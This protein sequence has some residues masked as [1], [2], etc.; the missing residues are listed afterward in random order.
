MKKFL[1]F[2]KWAFL[3]L[4]LM[5]GVGSIHA[6]RIV[7][8]SPK[9]RAS[10]NNLEKLGRVER[11]E[12]KVNK[13]LGRREYE[14]MLLKDPTTGKIPDNIKEK[15]LQYVNSRKAN[16]IDKSRASQYRTSDANPGDL[17]SPWERRGPHNVGGRTRALALDMSDNSGNTILAGG[18]SGGVWRTTNGGTSWTKT[19]GGTEN[20]SITYIAQ[21]PT[22]TDTW[23]Y[24]TGEGSGNSASEDGAFFLGRGVYKSIDN[25]VTWSLLASTTD[26]SPQSFSTPFEVAWKVVVHPSN[27]NVYV[28]TYGA[29]YRSAD[30]GDNWTIVL[31]A[32]DAYYTDIVVTSTGVLYAA[33]SS[34][35]SSDGV[36]RSTDN[37]N[38]WT[39]ITSG[40]P[41]S[42][43]RINMAIAPSNEDI[44]YML[45]DGTS[46]R[47]YKYTYV[48]GDGSGS[49]GTWVN[50]TVNMPAFGG[51]VGDYDSQGGYN[52]I[53][54]VYPSDENIVFVGGTNLYRSTDGFASDE[55]TEWIGGYSTDND[56]S[57][58]ANHHPDQH[59]LI[60]HPTDS[61]IAF[62]S[63]DGGISKTLDI[64][65]IDNDNTP[66]NWTYLNNGY[67]TTQ[68]YTVAIDH[69][70]TTNEYL[71]AG[72]Q[73]N[74]TWFTSTDEVTDPWVENFGGDG[75]YCAIAN[76][77]LVRYVS[78]QN[79]SAYRLSYNNV[80]DPNESSWQRVT[81]SGASGFLF[82]NPFIL[83][84]TNENQMFFAAGNFVWRND[85]LASLPTFNNNNPTAGWTKLTNAQA[86]G[87]VSAL[88][89]SISP[90]NRLYFGTTSG[91]IYR[92]DDAHTGNPSGSIISS[93]KGLPSGNVTSIAIDPNNA[94]RFLVTFSNYNIK[95]VFYTTD[96]GETF[97]DVSG[98]LEE[99]ANGSGNGPSVRSSA[100]IGY[101]NRYLVGTSTGLYSTTTLNGTST[102]WTREDLA[103]T[104]NIVVSMIKTRTNDGFV[105][106]AT[107]G[108]A[109]YSAK[110]EIGGAPLT[111]G[112]TT[113]TTSGCSPLV[114][115]FEDT[116][117]GGE[118]I[119]SW[120][121]DF[122]GGTPNEG[123][124]VNSQNPT[125]TFIDAGTY[126]ITLTV[127]DGTNTDA[128]TKTAYI[129]VFENVEGGALL[130]VEGFEGETFP[131]TNWTINNPNSNDTFTRANVGKGSSFSTVMDNYSNDLTG[132][133]DMLVMPTIS[134]SL[135]NLNL[136]FDVSY[137]R[138]DSDYFEELSIGIKS[139]CEEDYTIV[140]TKAGSELA[141]APDN[142]DAFVPSSDNE[143][144][145]ENIDLS[146]YL[147]GRDN[148][149]VAFINTSGYGNLLYLDNIV[150]FEEE[151]TIASPTNLMQTAISGNSVSLSWEDNADNEDAYEI[152]RSVT[153][154]EQDY[155]K[156]GEVPADTETY[157]DEELTPNTT[158][159][160][161]VRAK[162]N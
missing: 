85:D 72:F 47:F 102:V 48:S 57:I 8:M 86:S 12:A 110:Y 71:M 11:G 161:R 19:T 126:T 73:D 54:R 39:N 128:E 92:V 118:V 23:Y 29:I 114:V 154:N 115:N 62:S 147:A 145:S 144:R 69:T 156:I 7:K 35:G 31:D 28:A 113:S 1:A 120:I 14:L 26:T 65:A 21:D 41:T 84:A 18:V 78:A 134:T 74:G 107:H 52:L 151:I 135:N 40:F 109:L 141:T 37:G 93:G 98:N 76:G 121:W 9:Q 83:N 79:G 106:I 89:T 56:I 46:T 51:N 55:S 131:P 137:A 100:I 67:Y 43:G 15:E 99:N 82:I 32:G 53:C 3:L 87:T 70:N 36:F 80:T 66:V 13:Q 125:V 127:G 119:N 6:Q 116:S 5:I 158:Y 64:L 108:N 44:V 33:T 49:G 95:S 17:T 75:S 136:N 4:M 157:T 124:T 34:D 22:D 38:N 27:S 103:G 146:S 139:S 94:D 59:N 148:L 133:K 97:T 111:A 117:F 105:A 42:Y 129:E 63:H 152:W 159:Y 155:E 24:V 30:G 25:G 101:G 77:G 90:A 162:K 122:S 2:N 61:D 20:H 138:Y 10:H 123:S 160:Y 130:A 91:N 132:Q 50:R 16:L 112:F 140:W 81:P 45:V 143:W 96:G 149:T 150:L 104:E 68:P 88:A 153:E 58:Y 60:F 142:S